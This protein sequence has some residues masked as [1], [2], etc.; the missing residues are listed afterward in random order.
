MLWYSPLIAGTMWVKAHKLDIK[1]LKST[2]MH[3][4]G[5]ILVSFVTALILAILLDQFQ[6]MDWQS[7]LVF[8]MFLWIGLIATS[9]FSGVIWA[10]KPLAVYFIDVTYL[11]VSIVMMSVLLSIWL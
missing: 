8:A 11:L 7:A 6:I 10:H 5:S 2:P 9:H 4:I 3:Y 1:K